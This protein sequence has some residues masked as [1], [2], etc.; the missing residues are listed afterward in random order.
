MQIWAVL[1]GDKLEKSKEGISKPGDRELE[2]H[3]QSLFPDHGRYDEN[4]FAFC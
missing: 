4:N 2:Y 3:L 1:L